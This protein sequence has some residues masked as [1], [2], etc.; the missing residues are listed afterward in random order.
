[1]PIKSHRALETKFLKKVQF[2]EKWRYS[3]FFRQMKTEPEI[4]SKNKKFKKYL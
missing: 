1:V 4:I 2:I 3:L